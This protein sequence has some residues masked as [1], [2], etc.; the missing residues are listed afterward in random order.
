MFGRP[1]TLRPSSSSSASS[2]RSLSATGRNNSIN[3]NNVQNALLSHRSN[4][5]TVL[6]SNVTHARA[7]KQT[8]GLLYEADHQYPPWKNQPNRFL[9]QQQ[10]PLNPLHIRAQKKI[11]VC[12]PSLLSLPVSL[13]PLL[14]FFVFC[15]LGELAHTRFKWTK[16][17]TNFHFFFCLQIILLLLKLFFIFFVFL[18]KDYINFLQFFHAAFFPHFSFVRPRSPRTEKIIR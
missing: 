9:S 10:Q 17:G 5:R 11:F 15:R 16:Y 7:L 6:C 4:N 14:F 8:R 12:F 1:C 18:Q 2:S 13:S 3:N